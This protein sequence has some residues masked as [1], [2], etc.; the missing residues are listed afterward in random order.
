MLD[1]PVCWSITDNFEC[2][3]KCLRCKSFFFLS[4]INLKRVMSCRIEI[5]AKK[6]NGNIL[7][8]YKCLIFVPF[9]LL[10][11][12]FGLVMFKSLAIQN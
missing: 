7:L 1:Q 4:F 10:T 11:S 12:N 2:L 6:Y 8:L 9:Y 5:I 3:D